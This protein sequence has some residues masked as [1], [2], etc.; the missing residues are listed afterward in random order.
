MDYRP[1]KKWCQLLLAAFSLTAT[2]AEPFSDDF[3]A[4]KLDETKWSTEMAFA[5]S[6]GPCYHNEFYASYSLERNIDFRK[7]HLRLKCDREIV[8]GVAPQGLFY[9][10]Q[11]LITSRR[12][13]TCGWF[14]IRA[15]YPGGKGMWPCLW[16][17]PED[18]QAWPPEFDIAEYFGGQ[19]KMHF[20]LVHGA[21]TSPV[22]D[23]TGDCET[24]FAGRW[25][26]YALEWRQGWAAWYVDGHLKQ[27]V[28][29]DHIPSCPMNLVISNSVSSARG[30]DGEPD[31]DT[32]FPNYLE[33][34]SVRIFD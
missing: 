16:L 5:G 11:A 26:T 7:G 22:W 25:H 1:M 21:A 24:E 23:S 9:Y 2:A 27:I 6:M 18:A 4:S 10:S 32:V 15:R 31:A 14:E 12:A 3:L 34:D 13:F 30:S 20:G 29:A 28:V 19:K 33:I 17:M 8:S